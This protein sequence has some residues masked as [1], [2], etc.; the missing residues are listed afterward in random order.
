MAATC[1]QTIFFSSMCQQIIFLCTFGKQTFFSEKTHSP[2][3]RII[4]SAPYG[5]E[6]GTWIPNFRIHCKSITWIYLYKENT[7][8]MDKRWG[9]IVWVPK[10]DSNWIFYQKMKCNICDDVKLLLLNLEVIIIPKQPVSMGVS[11]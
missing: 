2:P 7:K 3:P 9:K 10:I 11:R 6:S 4:W 8:L 1:Q 5:P